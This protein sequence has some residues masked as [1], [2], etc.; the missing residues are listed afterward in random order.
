MVR[1]AM[2]DWN[3]TVFIGSQVAVIGVMGALVAL[4]HNSVITDIL[5]AVS[6]SL[7][8]SGVVEKIRAK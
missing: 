6:G 7:A 5:I 1:T 3:K 8:G 2:M 4:G